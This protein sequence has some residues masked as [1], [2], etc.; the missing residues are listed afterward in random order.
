MIANS[1]KTRPTNP[2]MKTSGMKTAASEMVIDMI[3]KLISF[4]LLMEASNGC[5][6]RSIRRTVFS[7]KTIASSTRNPMA[8]VSAISDKL[9][10]LYPSARIAMN[11][12]RS[13]SGKA[14]AGISVSVAR[15]RKTKIT[16][17]TSAKA[18]SSVVWTSETECTMLSERSYMGVILIE[19]GSWAL[20][21][22]NNS[23]MLL[24]TSTAFAPARR[25]TATITVAEGTL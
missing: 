2:D 17:T 13:D 15:P 22:G 10:R 14:T 4:A 1:R 3:V 16:I 11:V 19:P 5:S 24:A 21:I 20:T 18:M 7:K 23:R 6:P 9:S 8:R 12:I 25:F